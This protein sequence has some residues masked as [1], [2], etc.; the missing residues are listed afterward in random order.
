MSEFY[1]ELLK[2][3]R[4]LGKALGFAFED[5]AD[6]AQKFLNNQKKMLDL[7]LMETDDKSYKYI[8]D[9]IEFEITHG[10]AFASG[11]NNRTVLNG[12]P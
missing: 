7:K 10:V 8:E 1:L 9:F 4:H 5:I 2:Y 11:K 6:K 12:H 3:F